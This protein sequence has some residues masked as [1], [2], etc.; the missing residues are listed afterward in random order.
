MTIEELIQIA[1]KLP[2]VTYDIKWEH[3]LC[4][5]IADKMFL[6]TSPDDN[7]VSAS[8]KVAEEDFQE[9]ISLPGCAAAAYMGRYHWVSIDDISRFDT[10]T[11]TKVLNESY[12]LI[13]SKLSGKKQKELGIV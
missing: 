3:H 12:R 10:L 1:D 9:M 11:W 2:S 6:I 7:P 4:F 5:N 13:A 8:F